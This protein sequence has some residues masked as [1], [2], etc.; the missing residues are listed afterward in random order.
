MAKEDDSYPQIL[1]HLEFL[2]YTIHDTSSNSNKYATH[3]VDPCWLLTKF[4][5]G[6]GFY[7]NWQVQDDKKDSDY[8]EYKNSLNRSVIVGSFFT[9]EDNDGLAYNALYIYP[10]EKERLGL[11]LSLLKHDT[12]LVHRKESGSALKFLL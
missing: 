11:F 2:G 6:F 10:Y 9:P 8:S 4:G 12:E 1:N 7:R 3:P 5:F